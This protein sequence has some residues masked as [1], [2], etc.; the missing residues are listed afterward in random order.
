M[1]REENAAYQATCNAAGQTFG[2]TLGFTG[3]TLL[4]QL[5]VVEL[6]GFL[7][8]TGVVFIIV[9]LGVAV[10]KAETPLRKGDEPE[11]GIAAGVGSWKRGPPNGQREEEQREEVT[12]LAPRPLAWDADAHYARAKAAGAEIL[13]DIISQI[14]HTSCQ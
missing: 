11:Y 5:K 8:Y 14:F 3:A 4:Q 1:L 12:N 6:D 13:L 7:Y 10:G 2:F 9:T